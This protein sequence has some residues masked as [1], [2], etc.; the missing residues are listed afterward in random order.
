MYVGVIIWSR[1]VMLVYVVLRAFF[2]VR[3]NASA[4]FG[5]RRHYLTTLNYTRF[6][7][8]AIPRVR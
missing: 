6:G 1:N 7:L 3:S 5:E 8:I 4:H 2:T